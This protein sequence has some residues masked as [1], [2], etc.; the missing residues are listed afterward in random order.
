M[1][2][3]GSGAQVEAARHRIDELER[4][5]ERRRVRIEELEANVQK[6][7]KER[8]ASQTTTQHVLGELRAERRT[9]DGMRAA[10]AQ[11]EALATENARLRNRIDGLVFA[12]GL[13]DQHQRHLASVI[14]L[15]TTQTGYRWSSKASKWVSMSP[16]PA[17]AE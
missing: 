13:A 11:N 6:A 8:D 1:A 5:V 7:L 9:V 2:K 17:V 4:L 3:T 14:D 10:A 16:A 15:A 12:I